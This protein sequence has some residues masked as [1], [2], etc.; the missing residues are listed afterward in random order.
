MD[1]IL[2]YES[3]GGGSSPLRS[4]IENLAKELKSHFSIIG[5]NLYIRLITLESIYKCSRGVMD[6]QGFPKP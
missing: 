4:T 1:S 5:L 3:F 6:A 2:E